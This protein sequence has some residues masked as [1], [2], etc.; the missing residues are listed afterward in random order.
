MSF[1]IFYQLYLI[2]Q[3]PYGIC[4]FCEASRHFQTD[5]QEKRREFEAIQIEM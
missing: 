2:L 1:K 3:R 5:K 4:G